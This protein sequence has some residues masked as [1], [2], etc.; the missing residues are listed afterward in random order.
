MIHIFTWLWHQEHA[1]TVYTHEHVNIWA[2]MI[3]RNI[4]VPYRLSCVTDMPEG[5]DPSIN[6]IPL[7]DF[8]RV[9]NKHWRLKDGKPQCYRRLDM[10]R[11]DAAGTYGERF[12]SMDLDVCILGNIDEI[13]TL[14]GDL[15]INRSTVERRAYNGALVMMDAGARPQVFEKFE[16][17][18]AEIASG[19]YLGSDQAWYAY[20]LGWCEKRFGAEHGVCSYAKPNPTF[21]K[22]GNDC[23]MVF[24]PGST[25]PWHIHKHGS[26]L[27]YNHY[28]MELEQCPQ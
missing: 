4:T 3:R 27:I 14:E 23:R 21:N 15:I 8:P 7:P 17:R 1:K 19:M 24:F 25:K 9:S 13:V 2:A 10:F 6:I 20:V 12:M 5:I 16:P 18:L 28:K 11:H 26:E 22:P